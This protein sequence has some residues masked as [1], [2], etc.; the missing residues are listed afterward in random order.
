ML[1]R[2]I[3]TGDIFQ[4]RFQKGVASFTTMTNETSDLMNNPGLTMQMASEM[5]Y[6]SGLLPSEIVWCE[7]KQGVYVRVGIGGDLVLV[8]GY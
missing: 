1:I 4:R 5:D 3:K 2:R 8:M 7:M 6:F